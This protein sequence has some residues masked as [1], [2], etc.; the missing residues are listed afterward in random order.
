MWLF[1]KSKNFQRVIF[2]YYL[3][4]IWNLATG[5]VNQEPQVIKW[6]PSPV[7]ATPG[8]SLPVPSL[9]KI[10]DSLQHPPQH[11]YLSILPSSTLS[12]SCTQLCG[13]A[14]SP[15]TAWLWGCLP[16]PGSHLSPVPTVTAQSQSCH[17]ALW[18][19]WHSAATPANLWCLLPPT[20]N[21]ACLPWILSWAGLSFI[22][23]TN[24]QKKSNPFP[25][26]MSAQQWAQ[27]NTKGQLGWQS[28]VAEAKRL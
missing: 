15:R 25:K 17:P 8:W 11:T 6:I 1:D 13:A 9:S 16:C 7:Q 19:P 12:L 14:C 27:E 4:S 2:S 23:G 26:G 20:A 28:M 22:W 18:L 10:R 3:P 24:K 21:Q 5:H